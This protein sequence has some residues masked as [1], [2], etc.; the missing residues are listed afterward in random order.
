MT[1]IA[2]DGQTLAADSRLTSC[3][4]APAGEIGKAWKT[5]DGSRWAH[6]GAGQDNAKLREWAFGNRND[7]PPKIEEGVLVHIAPDGGVRQWWG[8]GWIEAAAERFA[9]GSGEHC[10]LAAMMAGAEAKRAVE[11]SSYLDNDTGGAITVL[12]A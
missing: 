11:I 6:A 8:E 1:T 3:N 10:A 2:F 12:P 7:P 4:N 9:W 5:P